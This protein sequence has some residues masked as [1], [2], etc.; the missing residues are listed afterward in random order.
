MDFERRGLLFTGLRS[1]YAMQFQ[2]DAPSGADERMAEE[3]VSIVD[4][5]A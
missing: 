3:N 2:E 4:V 1:F 5:D